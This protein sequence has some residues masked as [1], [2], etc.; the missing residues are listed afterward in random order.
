MTCGPTDGETPAARRAKDRARADNPLTIL[1]ALAI[2]LGR[3]AAQ[4]DFAKAVEE[5][6]DTDLSSPQGRVP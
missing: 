2:E 4:R 1:D 5:E 6:A 3:L